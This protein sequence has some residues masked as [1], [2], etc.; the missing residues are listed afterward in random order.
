MTDSYEGLEATLIEI[1]GGDISVTASDDGL[2]A[3]SPSST[4]EAFDFHGGGMGEVD[5][6]CSISISGGSLYVNA[7][8]D[9]LDSN[10]DLAVSGGSVT[11]E[12]PTDNG[13][14]P[15]DYAG[16][17][18]ITGGTVIVTGSSGMA[19]NFGAASTQGSLLVNLSE[20]ESGAITLTGTDGSVLMEFT[21]SKSY[22]SVLISCAAL[23][24][25]ET[26]T[27]TTGA[28]TAEITMSDLV[29]SSGSAAPGAGGPG[30]FAG[31]TR[32]GGPSGGTPPQSPPDG[33]A[34][35]KEAA[36]SA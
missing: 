5:A 14:G 15:L 19:M 4:E 16:E 20:A 29:F 3:A 33:L 26:Y 24:E 32:P 7:G 36:A 1:A 17:G 9:G 13:N 10:G 21:P 27:L 35:N 28:A 18:T 6:S 2:N 22:S 11:V 25:G 30:D 8:G 23:T 34:P 31:G 12:G